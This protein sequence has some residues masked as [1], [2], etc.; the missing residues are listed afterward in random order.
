MAMAISDWPEN[1]RPRERLLQQGAGALSEA[2]LLAIFLRVGV[3]GKSA[4]DLARDLL[5][6]FGS[7]RRLTGATLDEFTQI[8]GLG[9]ARFTQFQ[10]AP[11]R[12][13]RFSVRQDVIRGTP[14]R[15]GAGDPRADVT[16][17]ELF[18]IRPRVVGYQP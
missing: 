14:S 5:D 17:G 9:A 12:I 11:V 6:R 1:Q 13:Q 8:P 2:E 15:P 4:V 10:A 7:L 16:P 3:R 18:R